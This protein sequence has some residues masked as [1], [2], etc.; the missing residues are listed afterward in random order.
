MFLVCSQL[1]PKCLGHFLWVC[2]N[3][4]P[5]RSPTTSRRERPGARLRSSPIPES[6][7]HKASYYCSTGGTRVLCNSS[8][9]W[10]GVY[11]CVWY[12]ERV[13]AGNQTSMWPG[14]SR[15]AQYFH[16]SATEREQRKQPGRATPD[17]HAMHEVCSF[18]Q[19]R[20]PECGLSYDQGASTI[21]IATV[22]SIVRPVSF[23]PSLSSAPLS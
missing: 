23:L 13:I 5:F 15:K 8:E 11:R 4:G 18:V 17:R 2:H 21:T 1:L 14:P 6:V 9:G 3:T 10:Q 7:A 19:L 12:C 16:R 20:P 22:S